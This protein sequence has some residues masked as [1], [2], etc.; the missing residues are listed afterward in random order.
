MVCAKCVARVQPKIYSHDETSS[1]AHTILSP[2]AA[3]IRLRANTWRPRYINCHMMEERLCMEFLANRASE[4]HASAASGGSVWT[5]IYCSSA[6]GSKWRESSRGA[7]TNDLKTAFLQVQN[8]LT[9]PRPRNMAIRIIW[10]KNIFKV[11][12]IVYYTFKLIKPDKK[13]N[14]KTNK[15]KTFCIKYNYIMMSFASRKLHLV[16]Y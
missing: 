9:Q 14:N 12:E 13:K 1:F 3:V 5:N 4:L 11:G 10:L 7:R 2:A 8:Y 6:R 15:N 16:L